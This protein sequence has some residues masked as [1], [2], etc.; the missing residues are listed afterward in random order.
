MAT[1]FPLQRRRRAW[2]WL[3]P[4]LALA[5]VLV[6]L[7]VRSTGGVIRGTRSAMLDV[8]GPVRSFGD[9]ILTPIRNGWR[10]I[11]SYDELQ[12]ENITLRQELAQAEASVLRIGELERDRLDLIA[13]LG[14]RDTL[15]VIPRVAAR[16]IDAPVSNFER[17]IELEVGT[18]EGV[19]VGMPVESGGGLIGRVVQ[20]ATT[21]SRVE[22]LTDPNFDAGV[23]L[24]RSGDDGLASGR[25]ANL[26]LLV[27]FIDLG[28]VVIPGETVVTSGFSGSSFPSGLL[29]GTV[30]DVEPDA[31]QGTQRVGVHPAAD[32][33][34]LRWVQVLLYESDVTAP[35]VV[36][37]P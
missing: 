4:L 5:V 15:S 19:M 21:R 20:T 32:L 24:V 18:R 25:G 35:L 1:R 36:T 8:T 34:R 10:G 22:L 33:S 28:T 27:S 29:V 31:A 23:R 9:L 6:T 12:L 30:T 17:T 26:D 14:A 11:V 3:I 2:R 16:V 37:T 13:L 7:D